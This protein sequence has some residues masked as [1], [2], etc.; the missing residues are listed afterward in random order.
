MSMRAARFQ[1]A[2]LAGLAFSTASGAC[3]Q[4]FSGFYAGAHGLYDG[5]VATTNATDVSL[6]EKARDKR[7]VWGGY[8][9]YNLRVGADA[10]IGVET[11]LSLPKTATEARKI[12]QQQIDGAL[13]TTDARV[14]L[15]ASLSGS[16]GVRLGYLITPQTMIF[17]AGSLVA[18]REEASVSATFE[19][20]DGASKASWSLK[21][22]HIGWSVGGGVERAIGEKWSTRLEYVY[23]NYADKSYVGPSTPKLVDSALRTTSARIGLTYNF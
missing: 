17:A 9:G 15:N 20:Q 14:A 7:F 5:T 12:L 10:V 22:N 8:A 19:K 4:T 3:A 6:A 13:V 1:L 2:A 21:A 18:L 16:A 23:S 11:T